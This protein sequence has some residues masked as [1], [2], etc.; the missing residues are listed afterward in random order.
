MWTSCWRKDRTRSSI[1]SAAPGACLCSECMF[2][3]VVLIEVIVQYKSR[4]KIVI[5]KIRQASWE[6][7]DRTTGV[8]CSKTLHERHRRW[9]QTRRD[10]AHRP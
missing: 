3:F 1:P 7:V 9:Q 2:K 8:V 4:I 6:L 10:S 5:S